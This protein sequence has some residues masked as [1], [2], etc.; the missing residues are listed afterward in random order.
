[1]TRWNTPTDDVA[2]VSPDITDETNA[3]PARYF[4]EPEVHEMEQ[5]KIFGKYWTY[6]GHANCI[7]EPGEFFTRTIGGRQVIIVR[8]HDGEIRA[9]FNVCAHRGSKMVADTPM[10]DPGQMGRI[11]CPY[12]MWSYDLNGDLEST[13]QS[14]EEACINP[15]LDD[16]D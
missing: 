14:F 6:A 9:F 3:L 7:E 5:T 11:R 10:T 13:P 12:H 1:M 8:D 2:A 15:D 16:E 4:T